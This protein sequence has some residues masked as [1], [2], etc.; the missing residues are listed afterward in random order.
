M[1]Q[2]SVTVGNAPVHDDVEKKT[3]ERPV[4]EMLGADS[5]ATGNDGISSDGTNVT[6]ATNTNS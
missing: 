2:Q 6:S 3:Y 1:N 4:L 5:T